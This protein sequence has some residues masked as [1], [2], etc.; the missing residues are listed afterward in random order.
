MNRNNTLT[1]RL[2]LAAVLI[3]LGTFGCTKQQEN[4]SIKIG[5]DASLSGALAFWGESIQQGM[6]LAEE[7][8]NAEH[9]D[10]PAKLIS[11]DNQGDPKSSI[12]AMR[13]L[14]SID[15]VACVVGVMTPFS[16]PLRPFAAELKTPI[17][18]TVVVSL[19]FGAENE[20]SFRDYPTPDQLGSL[21]AEYAYKK[22]NL[23]RAVCLVVNDEYGK[24]S[25]TLFENRFKELGGQV[26]GSDTMAQ[27]DTDARNQITKLLAQSPDCAYVVIREN[28]LATAV[29]Q[30][31]ELGFKGQFLGINSFDS[32]VVWQGVGEYG[33]GIIFTTALIDYGGNPD[34]AAFAEAFKKRFSK[35]P[36]GTN[37]YGYSIGKY[38][39][40]LAAK[41]NGDPVKL[42]DLMASLDADSIRGHI[43]MQPTRDVLTPVAVY[44][45]KGGKNIILK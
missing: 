35:E 25:Q 26:L 22:L 37:A 41:A 9:P 39:F 40:A 1:V 38:L 15:H 28:A 7:Q 18:G 19:N 42:R 31:R 24:D 36:N 4:P 3:A 34:A 45:R 23:N 20:W 2:V 10:K 27:S 29:R 30:F 5:L 21:V 16:K 32:P 43:K 6:Q 11:E 33:E 12:S 13:K 14:C 17:L 44:Q 8:Y